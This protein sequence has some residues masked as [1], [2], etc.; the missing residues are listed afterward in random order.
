MPADP[1][2]NLVLDDEPP[3][4]HLVCQAGLCLAPL[5]KVNIFAG[6]NNEG[7]SRLLRHLFAMEQNTVPRTSEGHGIPY[8]DVQ[9]LIDA[10]Q[11]AWQEIVAVFRQDAKQ[12]QIDIYDPP[13]SRMRQR[14][15]GMDE[16]CPVVN[17]CFDSVEEMAAC[18]E[19]Y[20]AARRFFRSVGNLRSMLRNVLLTATNHS[21]VY[22][23]TLRGLRPFSEDTADVYA[24][25]TKEDYFSE[26]P[27]R[28]R[29]LFFTGLGLYEEVAKLKGGSNDERDIAAEHERFLAE[30]FF[31]GRR[32]T[33]TSRY[34]KSVVYVDLD[35]DEHAIH[36]KG[37]L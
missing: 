10:H 34:G 3:H 19:S 15:T 27:L 1:L 12:K 13:F 5:R 14:F 20:D 11:T 8:R 31:N 2:T 29:S 37:D 25:R 30:H 16:V 36:D 33:L 23:P 32:T 9:A 24:E 26:E 22:I 17:R 21:R 18:F 6:A 7:K 28:G 4:T 35:G